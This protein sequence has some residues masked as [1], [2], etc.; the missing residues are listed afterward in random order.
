MMKL[1]KRLKPYWLSITAVLVLTFGQVIGQLYLPTLMSN[2]ID[3]GVV[4]GD[5]DYIWSTGMQM[6]LISFASV[7]LSVI[8][9]YLASKISMGFGKDLRDKIFTKVE[10]FSLQEFDKVGTSSLI[11][12][13]TNDVVQIQN[14]LYMMMRLMVMAPIML[15]GGIIMAVGRDAK[16]SLIF[17]VVLPLLLLLVVVLGG[18][19]MPMFKSLQ[20]KMDK[21]NRVIREG[22]TGIRVVRSFNRNE[23]ELEKFEEANADYA[24]TA[25]KVNRLLSLMSP[26]MMLLMNLTSIA[27]V[28]IGS[29]FI[30]NGDMQVGDLMAFIQYAMQIMMSFMMLSAVFIMIPRAGAS[31]ERINEV[32]DMEAEI[33]NPEN[34]KTSTPPAKLSFENVTFRY[35]GAEKPVI[36]DISFEANAGETVAIIGST[37]AGKSTLIN[38]IPRF[39]DVESGVVKINGID[40]REMDQSSLRQKIGLVP[41]KAVLF[42]GTIASNMRYGKE[43]ATDEEIWEALRTAQAENFVSKLSNGLGSRVEQGGNNFSG[44]QKQ[45]LSIARSL[46]R[47]PEIYIFDDSFSALDFKT[48]A[49]LR[50]ALKSETTEAVTLI[51]AQRITSVV[52]SDQIIVLNEGKIAGIGTHEELKESNQ[53]YQEIMRSQLSEEE[54]A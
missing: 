32:L 49:K 25:I 1:M 44:G 35:E 4:N 5:T 15:L 14:V 21:L 10:D 40:V 54:I 8:V 53:I 24:T 2:I 22:L 17:V 31:A 12:R 47:K 45:R 9:V 20:K 13:T 26:L 36:E 41:Q 28:W 50:E 42:T 27:I 19:A 46:I 37:G 52:N 11:T 33:L 6:L 39:Y 29:I 3:K 38:M 18:K 43:D 7:I 23:D 34:P 48:D 30:G 51:V 16:L